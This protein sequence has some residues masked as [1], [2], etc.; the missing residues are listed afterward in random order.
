MQ[1]IS[2]ANSEK[3]ASFCGLDQDT[4]KHMSF[5]EYGLNKGLVMP[6][7]SQ[8]RGVQSIHRMRDFV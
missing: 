4:N 2:A 5:W 7:E 1:K 6:M 8:I 3:T